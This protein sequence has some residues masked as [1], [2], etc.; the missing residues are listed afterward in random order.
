[1]SVSSFVNIKM[2]GTFRFNIFFSAP[3]FVL[4]FFYVFV[5]LF[6]CGGGGRSTLKVGHILKMYLLQASNMKNNIIYIY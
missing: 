5:C 6:F 3:G 4:V 2:L 1:M